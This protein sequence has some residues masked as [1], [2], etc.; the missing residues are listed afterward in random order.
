MAISAD[1]A[2]G[3]NPATDPA[4]AGKSVGLPDGLFPS[5]VKFESGGNPNAVSKKGAVGAAQVEPASAAK[6]GYGIKPGDPR[7][8]RTGAR[9]LKGYLDGPAKGDYATAIAMYNAGPGGNLKNP[10]T[11]KY[12]D[13]VMKGWKPPAELLFGTEQ[14]A[15]QRP[16]G[17]PPQQGMSPLASAPPGQP[18]PQQKQPPHPLMDAINKPADR[19]VELMQ[20]DTQTLFND[21]N[22]LIKGPNPQ[23]PRGRA[24]TAFNVALDAVGL[25]FSPISSVVDAFVGDPATQ[26]AH[27]MGLSPK[28]DPYIRGAAQIALPIAGSKSKLL[29]EA[30]DPV[31]KFLT[32]AMDNKAA[33]SLAMSQS[34]KISDT[35]NRA[36]G[37]MDKVMT[38]AL[39]EVQQRAPQNYGDWKEELYH[40]VDTN[41]FSKLTPQAAA[42]W[43][44]ELEP[45]SKKTALLR[46]QLASYGVDV[47]QDVPNYI[48]RQRVGETKSKFF[49]FT[50]PMDVNRGRGLSR[51]APELQERQVHEVYDPNT[52]SQLI[53]VNDPETGKALAYRNKQVVGQGTIE[54]GKFKW[55]G[56][57]GQAGSLALDNA[58]VADIERHTDI[59]YHKDPIA[60][61]MQANVDMHRA[62]I[63]AKA[64][65]QIKVS[66][67]FQALARRPS[68]AAPAGWRE[69]NIPGTSQ[70]NRY[71]FDP[72]LAEVLED[73]NG[74]VHGDISQGLGKLNRVLV[75]SLFFNPLPHI[76]N[77]LTHSVVEKGLVGGAGALGKEAYRFVMPGMTTTTVDAWKA[78]WNKDANYMKYLDEG[79]GLM[80]PSVYTRNFFDQVL[81]AVGSSPQAAGLAR[82][83]GYANPVEWGKAVYGASR[84]S[85]WFVNDVIMMQAY[86][87]KERAGM[88][89][90]HAVAEVEKHVPN[91]RVPSRV[92]GSRTLSLAL[93]NPAI[94]AFG[95]YD[96]GRVAS[97]GYMLSDATRMDKGLNAVGRM[98]ALDQI[99]ATAFISFF[100]YPQVMDQAAKHLTGNKDASWVRYGPATIPSLVWEYMEG[101]KDWGSAMSTA[102]PSSPIIKGFSE[103]KSGRSEFSGQELFK[104]P[105]DV[106]LYAIKQLAPGALIA[107]V[108]AGK[109]GAQQQLW[110]QLGIKDPTPQQQ[111][112][113]QKWIARIKKERGIK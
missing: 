68:Q 41:D 39:H 23:D 88:T 94:S 66:P 101:N 53:V 86:L 112:K 78:V 75:G 81:K 20:Q 35:L 96:Y 83:F 52:K 72:H 6:P 107:D 64:I 26:L 57:G 7:D 48:S 33:S 4:A 70:F 106:A 34:E 10:T 87:E 58:H 18:Q 74:N 44:N 93:R 2:F 27:Y 55:S 85:L 80:Y 79:A 110:M 37:Q 62:L 92:L 25:P 40:A 43:K 69:V 21:I 8:L 100:V 13:D 28:V 38:R 31:A 14:T 9:I 103:I 105:D 42:F 47:G 32:G 45:V 17:Q 59:M 73:F 99:A 56:Q 12:V 49:D 50:A 84:K 46:Q 51:S 89:A 111:A 29:Q 60:S 102:L 22:H 90:A 97:Y 76:M 54:G 1:E 11:T 24:R 19:T 36:Q 71:K 82:A 91:Y 65:E 63:N 3:P 77:V 16:N 104:K 113:M 108:A 109:K 61:V 15:P 30:M 5:I 95:R 67:E 98:K